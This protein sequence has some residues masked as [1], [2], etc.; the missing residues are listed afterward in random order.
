MTELCE[1]AVINKT[2]FYK[3]YQDIFALSG[4][5]E[6]ETIA[7]IMVDFEDFD[8]LFS[9]PY[10][11]VKGL[12]TAFSSQKRLILV[13][14]A[15]RMNVLVAKVEKYL[16]AYYLSE[17]NTPEEDVVMSFLI[18]GAS[19]VLMEPRYDELILFNTVSD[20]VSSVISRRQKDLSQKI[21]G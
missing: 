18:G 7:G 4:E 13:L 17:K 2:T 3:H 9:N 19:H 5:I 6:N 21:D 10:D 1:L 14:F 16:K 15:D 8:A 11:F 12:Y 20:I